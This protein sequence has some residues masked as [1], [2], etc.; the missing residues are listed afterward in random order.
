MKS[1]DK[2]FP[3]SLKRTVPYWMKKRILFPLRP[4]VQPRR[5]DFRADELDHRPEEESLRGRGLY[6]VRGYLSFWSDYNRRV[7]ETVPSSRLLILRT[8]SISSDIVSMAEEYCGD[9]MKKFFP[10]IGSPGDVLTDG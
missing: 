5:A 6:T 9:L 4:L 8:D 1:G 2:Q 7:I 10:E 3:E